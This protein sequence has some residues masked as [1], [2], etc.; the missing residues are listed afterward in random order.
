[1]A[2]CKAGALQPA[3][4]A[5]VQDKSSEREDCKGIGGDDETEVDDAACGVHAVLQHCIYV[6]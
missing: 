3:L 4:D 2:C 1:M 5:D 6:F